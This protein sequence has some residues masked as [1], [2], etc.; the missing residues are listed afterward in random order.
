MLMDPKLNG[1]LT[2]ALNH[3]MAAVQQYL[4]QA[5]LCQYWGLQQA[6]DQFRYES[7]DELKHA[8]RLISRMLSLGLLPR[9][10]QLPPVSAT[11]SLKDMLIVDWHLEEEAIHLYDEASQYAA[12][13]RD[14]ESFKLF[15]ELLLEEREHLQSLEKWLAELEQSGN[16]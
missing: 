10:T 13:I 3:E 7:E 5:T 12:R 16:G 6:S 4:T 15:T 2:R 1:Y 14:E 11:R 9:A 8:Q